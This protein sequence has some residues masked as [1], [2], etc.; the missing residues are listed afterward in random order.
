[1]EFTAPKSLFFNCI[2][3]DRRCVGCNLQ[4]WL[5]TSYSSL[6]TWCPRRGVVIFKWWP[7]DRR[8]FGHLDIRAC[9]ELCNIMYS[10]YHGQKLVVG[11]RVASLI[12][13]YSLPLGWMGKIFFCNLTIMMFW[14]AMPSLNYGFYYEL[15]LC[16]ILSVSFFL[17]SCLAENVG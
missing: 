4:K 16:F 15:L 11:L 9:F 2:R 1:M 8:S 3:W 17:D 7:R 10:I 14:M 12:S 5:W 13:S 6:K